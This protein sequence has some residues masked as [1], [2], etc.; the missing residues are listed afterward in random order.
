MNVDQQLAVTEEQVGSCAAFSRCTVKFKMYLFNINTR[1]M[2]VLL[3]R[4]VTYLCNSPVTSD[5]PADSTANFKAN[6]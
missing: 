2:Y 6:L 1:L 3:L 4:P 5:S